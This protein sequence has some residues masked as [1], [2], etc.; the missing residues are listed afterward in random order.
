V[1]LGRTTL[2]AAGVAGVAG[3][4][5]LTGCASPFSTLRPAGPE[6][7]AVATLGWW[8]IGFF[9]LVTVA[10]GVLIVWGALRRRGTLAEHLPI[11]IDG[12]KKWILFGGVALPVTVLSILF[13]VTLGMLRGVP[14]TVDEP[15]LSIEV[16]GHQWWWEVNYLDPDLQQRF[17]TA[18]EIHIPV[19]KQVQITLKSGDVIHSFWVPRLHGKLDAIPGHTNHL[20]L[21]ASEPGVYWGE[22]AEFCG[23]QHAHMRLTV[24]AEPEAAFLAWVE[25]QRQPARMPT[26]PRLVR[27]REAF[28]EYACGLCHT[29]RGTQARGGVA[30]DLTHFG[31]R[32]TIGAGTVPNTRARLQAWIVNAQGIKPGSR[33]PS[34]EVFDGET[35]N[36]LAEYLESLE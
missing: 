25:R 3:V 6:A 10:M 27:G 19:G 26:E 29:I 20:I 21:E 4:A 22:C 24:V 36:V 30:P 2:R 9:L 23:V 28:E 15:D 8:I 7:A 16:V 32:L 18:N 35:L 34:L 31:S 33:M 11:D 14:G 12:G 5:L 1:N 13:L 17:S